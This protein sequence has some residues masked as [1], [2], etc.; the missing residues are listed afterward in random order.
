MTLR[1][2]IKEIVDKFFDLDFS[3]KI[4]FPRRYYFGIEVNTYKQFGFGFNLAF[5]TLSFNLPL[6][7][8]EFDV[9]RICPSDCVGCKEQAESDKKALK[10]AD[11]IDT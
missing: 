3:Y 4:I 7:D 6:L 11:N 2:K 10:G 1:E 9:G 5:N 8:I